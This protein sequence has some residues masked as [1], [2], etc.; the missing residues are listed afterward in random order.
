MLSGLL[1][2]WW[3]SRQLTSL[4]PDIL[5]LTTTI[6]TLQTNLHCIAQDFGKKSVEMWNL[7]CVELY[8]IYSK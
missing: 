8:E 6:I 1:A 2:L 5:S 3:Q 7:L 4:R